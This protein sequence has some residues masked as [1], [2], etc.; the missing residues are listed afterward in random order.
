MNFVNYSLIN[1]SISPCA[2]FSGSLCNFLFGFS[3]PKNQIEQPMGERSCSKH[4]PEKGH[5]EVLQYSACPDR[6][7]LRKRLLRQNHV[8]QN[9]GNHTHRR[10]HDSDGACLTHQPAEIRIVFLRIAMPLHKCRT[11]AVSPEIG[12]KKNKYAH[13]C[14]FFQ[15]SREHSIRHGRKAARVQIEAHFNGDVVNLHPDGH[16]VGH[17][18][19][20]DNSLCFCFRHSQNLLKHEIEKRSLTK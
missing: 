20:K 2:V 8:E 11:T 13:V 6:R 10:A 16:G 9:R 15:R 17:N 3:F 1:G 18:D 14:R 12:K 19:S 4:I 5:G 7:K